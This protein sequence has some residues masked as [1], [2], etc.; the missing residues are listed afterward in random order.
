MKKMNLN[1]L[2]LPLLVG[3][4][5]HIAGAE[6]IPKSFTIARYQPMMARSPFSVATAVAAPAATPNF[7]KDLYVANASHTND[8][9]LVTV[10]S[11]TDK[12]FKKYL[13]TTAPVDGYSVVGIDWSDKVGATKVTISKDGSIATIGFNEALLR[14]PGQNPPPPPGKEKDGAQ[15]QAAAQVAAPVVPGAPPVVQP[16]AVKPMPVPVLPSTQPARVRGVIPRNPAP[17]A[18][19]PPPNG[20]VQPSQ[21]KN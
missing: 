20:V 12:M 8:G 1:R 7:A 13:T 3:V 10:A 6:D 5:L 16:N 17:N 2:L 11:T 15:P 19:V 4:P 18:A 21:E 14:Q 9:D